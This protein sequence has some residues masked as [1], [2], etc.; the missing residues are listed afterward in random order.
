LSVDN[1][2]IVAAGAW[3]HSP[4]RGQFVIVTKNPLHLIGELRGYGDSALNSRH[5][6][7]SIHVA[8]IECTVT[9]IPEASPAPIAPR[10]A[11]ER[12][13]ALYAIETAI[14]GRTQWLNRSAALSSLSWSLPI[15]SISI[16]A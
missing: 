2:R 7:N 3:P 4:E 13:A 9:D 15:L 1:Q 14:R 10:E 16:C 5:E 11:L 6:A 12:I 8:K